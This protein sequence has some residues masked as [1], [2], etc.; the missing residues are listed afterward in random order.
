MDH[1]SRIGTPLA[2]LFQK[3]NATLG[4]PEEVFQRPEAEGEGIP[5]DVL[6]Y[7]P[8][9]LPFDLFITLGASLHEQPS[10]A[11]GSGDT[12]V[13][14][15][16]KIRKGLSVDQRKEFARSLWMLSQ[17][18]FR[19]EKKQPMTEWHTLGGLQPL[20]RGSSYE[21]FLLKPAPAMDAPIQALQ[22]ELAPGRVLE[23]IGITLEEFL[24]LHVTA[25]E[26][27]EH[28]LRVKKFVADYRSDP[29]IQDLIGGNQP[30][31]H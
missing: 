26:P 15:Y 13:E 8:G 6:I 31:Y 12:R 30:T 18:P 21:G 19:G 25:V 28:L 4:A 16:A 23:A 7:Q 27:Q 17:W 1:A 14:Y 24:Q 3:Y 5:V 22:A 2:A 9:A 11:A 10:G 29:V 20:I